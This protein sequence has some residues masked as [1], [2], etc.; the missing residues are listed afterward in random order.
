MDYWA[1]LD[2]KRS[3]KKEGLVLDLG[4]RV[5]AFITPDDPDRSNRSFENEPASVRPDRRFPR[6]S[7]KSP[8]ATARDNT[9]CNGRLATQ[10]IPGI[11]GSDLRDRGVDLR[12]RRLGRL[13]AILELRLRGPRFFAN[14][15]IAA[16]PNRSTAEDDD[17]DQQIR[18][19]YL[20]YE[21]CALLCSSSLV[22]T[23]PTTRRHPMSS[24]RCRPSVM[25]VVV[26]SMDGTD[27]AGTACLPRYG[28]LG[29][30]VRPAPVTPSLTSA[31]AASAL[32]VLS[33]SGDRGAG[34]RL[35]LDGRPRRR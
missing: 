28:K 2:A 35:Q 24:V 25:R 13:Q 1:N 8:K 3:S 19:E 27:H 21:T 31:R 10:S 20:T 34:D 7:S 12:L 29:R 32:N 26:H 18:P 6:R 30:R 9:R 22:L 16:P 17:H 23:S 11:V 15:G 33:T 5:K 14:L 4:K